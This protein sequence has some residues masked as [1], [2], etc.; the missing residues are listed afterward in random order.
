MKRSKTP[1][2]VVK[3]ASKKARCEKLDPA[4]LKS[5]VELQNE[6]SPNSPTLERKG[7]IFAVLQQFWERLKPGTRS[8]PS[9]AYWAKFLL[10]HA[11]QTTRFNEIK[12][13]TTSAHTP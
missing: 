5:N 2:Q 6:A 4:N 1:K 10:M 3:E 9:I 8:V 7:D 12:S 13:S 11:N